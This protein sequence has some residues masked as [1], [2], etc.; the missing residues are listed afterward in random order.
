MLR[1]PR[2]SVY[3]IAALGATYRPATEEQLHRLL[4]L[5]KLI[6]ASVGVNEVS[7]VHWDRAKLLETEREGRLAP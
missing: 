3:L 2:C 4:T 7:E 5:S 1:P 6:A